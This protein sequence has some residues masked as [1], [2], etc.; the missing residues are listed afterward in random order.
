M[1]FR[2]C[3][4]F[5]S[6]YS[7]FCQGTTTISH[8]FKALAIFHCIVCLLCGESIPPHRCNSATSLGMWIGG[9]HSVVV[10]SQERHWGPLAVFCP[11]NTERQNYLAVLCLQVYIDLSKQPLVIGMYGEGTMEVSIVTFSRCAIVTLNM[12]TDHRGAEH[13]S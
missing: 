10:C 8:S 9:G 3:I 7:I 1:H 6:V 13:S 5:L 4:P 11:Y 12:A 2:M